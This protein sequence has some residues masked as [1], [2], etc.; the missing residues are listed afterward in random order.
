MVDRVSDTF[1]NVLFIRTEDTDSLSVYIYSPK[2]RP[3]RL[4]KPTSVFYTV[5]VGVEGVTSH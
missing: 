1:I 5:D 3:E 4:S 2:V